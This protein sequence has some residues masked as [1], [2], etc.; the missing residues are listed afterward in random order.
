MYIY[1]LIYDGINTVY[2]YIWWYLDICTYS[3][4][5]RSRTVLWSFRA[6]CWRMDMVDA[7]SSMTSVLRCTYVAEGLCLPSGMEKNQ[8]KAWQP[9]REKLYWKLPFIVDLPIKNCDFPIVMLNYQRVVFVWEHNHAQCFS[10]LRETR[11]VPEVS[12]HYMFGI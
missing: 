10:K 12:N 11:W 8:L 6:E 7:A 3:R 4:Q 5:Q 2:T 1:I 9:S